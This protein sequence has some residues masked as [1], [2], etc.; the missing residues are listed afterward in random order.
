MVVNS[1]ILF[2]IHYCVFLVTF[3]IYSKPEVLL[4]NIIAGERTTFQC[5]KHLRN[6]V[7]VYQVFWKLYDIFAFLTND[8][9]SRS[10]VASDVI[11]GK[12]VE[13]I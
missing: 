5:R 2:E 4:P 10:E 11:S 6:T 8:A 12:F 7:I 3:E 13:D 1:A 9:K